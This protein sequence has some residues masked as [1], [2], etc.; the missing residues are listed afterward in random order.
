MVSTGM[1][2]QRK[3]MAMSTVIWVLV[4]VIFF[5]L[6]VYNIVSFAKGFQ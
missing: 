4:V 6:M 1:R 3:G 5:A 2:K